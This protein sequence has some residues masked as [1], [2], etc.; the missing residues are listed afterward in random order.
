MIWRL[1]L[2]AAL[3]AF[4]I[5]AQFDEELDEFSLEERTPLSEEEALTQLAAAFGTAESAARQEA[6]L[7]LFDTLQVNPRVILPPRDW[8]KFRS[9]LANEVAPEEVRARLPKLLA[10]AADAEVHPAATMRLNLALQ[11][12]AAVG[13]AET[14]ELVAILRKRPDAE[15]QWL[16]PALGRAGGPSVLP[17]LRR[18]RRDETIMPVNHPPN[19]RAE[20]CAAV[21]G[22]AYAGDPEAHALILAWYE[23]DFLA[24]PRHAFNV[25]W[26]IQEGM[27]PDY[28]VLDYCGQ[29]LNQAERYLDSRPGDQLSALIR[30]ANDQVA[31]ALTDYLVRRQQQAPAEESALFLP[32]LA[33]PTLTV[34]QPVLQ[35][36]MERG[37][38]G[39]RKQALAM[40]ETQLESP[41][42]IER[43]AAATLLL[44]HIPDSVVER[45]QRIAENDPSPEL[46]LRLRETLRSR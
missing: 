43:F 23:E 33:N 39:L 5:Q 24:R 27:V 41:Y 11:L 14:E 10:G 9:A 1:L 25:Q 6:L 19:I 35:L 26:T 4:P 40:L 22:C 16:L 37:E 2:L 8:L 36:F 15:L 3:V 46:R 38:P 21:L 45:V 28:R 31:I 18:H 32:L 30:H 20:A 17:I 13:G 34:K 7:A 29:R 44:R 12:A 42:A